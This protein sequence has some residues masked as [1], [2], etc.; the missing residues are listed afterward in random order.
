MT[1][2]RRP[3][4]GAVIAGWLVIANENDRGVVRTWLRCVACG[5]VRE[6]GRYG[7]DQHLRRCVCRKLRPD[8]T[9][10]EVV[11]LDALPFAED[12]ACQRFVDAHPGGATLEEIARVVG[13]TRERVRQLEE[14]ALSAFRR[15]AAK[16]GDI[17]AEDWARLAQNLLE[18][19]A[20]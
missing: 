16:V 20:A 3:F 7:I 12:V 1:D 4:V 9:P 15:A 14:Q 2:P 19:R 17:D 11:H 13:F 8:V 5:R 18:G 6:R 10:D